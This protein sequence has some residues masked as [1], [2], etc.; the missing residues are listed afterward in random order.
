MDYFVDLTENEFQFKY[1]NN[2]KKLDTL[3]TFKLLKKILKIMTNGTESVD[4]GF[5]GAITLL[6][7]KDNMD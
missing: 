5:K 6:K 1:L 2:F 4:W 3:N 7:I